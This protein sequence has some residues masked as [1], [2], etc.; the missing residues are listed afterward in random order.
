MQRSAM[1]HNPPPSYTGV[2]N[3]PAPA[4]TYAPSIFSAP[5]AKDATPRD[6]GKVRVPPAGRP[7]VELPLRRQW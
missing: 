2:H 3:P 6:Q 4:S 7:W 1:H 5:L